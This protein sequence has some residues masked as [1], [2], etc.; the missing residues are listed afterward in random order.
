MRTEIIVKYIDNGIIAE[1]EHLTNDG[2]VLVLLSGGNWEYD[3]VEEA[4]INEIWEVLLD[5][6]EKGIIIDPTQIYVHREFEN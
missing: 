5:A 4:Q 2:Q 3:N 6:Q 1:L